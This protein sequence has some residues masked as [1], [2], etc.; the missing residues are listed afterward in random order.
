[1]I[2]NIPAFNADMRSKEIMTL[3]H[4][5]P[6]CI[7]I[8][9]PKEQCMGYVFVLKAEGES[10]LIIRERQFSSHKVNMKSI[11]VLADDDDVVLSAFLV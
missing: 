6:K 4:D 10:L 11:L 9:F 7:N 8:D 5:K 2:Y 1:M 3:R